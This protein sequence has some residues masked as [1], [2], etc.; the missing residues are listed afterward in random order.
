MRIVE[1]PSVTVDGCDDAVSGPVK[2]LPIVSNGSSSHEKLH[3]FQDRSQGT[4]SG[5]GS[6]GAVEGAEE[7]LRPMTPGVKVKLQGRQ[8]R[9]RVQISSILQLRCMALV[10]M[11]APV[12]RVFHCFLPPCS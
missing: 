6:G 10:L 1:Q 9:R 5:G 8:G 4:I 11:R 12:H 7:R 3:K 2:Q